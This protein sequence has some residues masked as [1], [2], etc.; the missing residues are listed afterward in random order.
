MQRSNDATIGRG[1]SE[2]APATMQ[3]T[4]SQGRNRVGEE[5]FFVLVNRA[6]GGGRCGRLADQALARLRREGLKL[7]TADSQYPGHG[8]ELVRAAYRDGFRRFVAMGG[9]GTAYE[10]VNG[11]FPQA[12]NGPV[13]LAFQPLGT[14][15]SF[16]RDFTTEGLA[17]ATRALLEGRQRACDV[18][19]LRHRDG[20][21]YS[22]NLL[23]LGF[24]ADVAALTNRRFKRLGY[25]G[26]L[27]GVFACLARLSR[28]PFPVRVDAAEEFD[29]RRHLFLTF[30]NSKFTGGTMMIAPQADIASGEVEY[31][32]WGPV[33][34]LALVR[35]LHT[36]YDGSH[37]NH[38]LASRRSV[39]SVEFALDAPVD[40]MVDGEV[41]T[42]HP[43]KLDVL[44]GALRVMV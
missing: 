39:R 37:L 36:L 24:T 9:D 8:T 10:I 15:N 21:L 23:S 4:S 40:V 5:R 7:E 18:L 19:R 25:P 17:H 14:G 2:P 31:V 3:N 34:R 27:L 41:L 42:L 38:P 20:E 11:V 29:R 6:A 22:I 35:N 12:R 16:L 26:Y 28:R 1:V 30:N 32:R 44:P 13:T 33:G 43:E